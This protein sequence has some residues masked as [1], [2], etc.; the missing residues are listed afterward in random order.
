MWTV[1]LVRLPHGL[2]LTGILFLSLGC[3]WGIRKVGSLCPR[4]FSCS[5][6]GRGPEQ[7][8]WNSGY[9]MLSAP[10]CETPRMSPSGFIVSSFSLKFI[11]KEKKWETQMLRQPCNWGTL[12][13][14]SA[15]T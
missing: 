7:N 4:A 3:P 6:A 13:C 8:R 9:V 2:E 14:Q 5:P 11:T 15:C 10:A 1:H 12:D